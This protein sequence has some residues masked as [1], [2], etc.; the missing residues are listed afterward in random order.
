MKSLAP[1]AAIIL[2]SFVIVGCTQTRPAIPANPPATSYQVDSFEL[3]ESGR[4]QKVRGA[5]VTPDFFQSVKE[6]PMLG[7]IFIPEDYSLGRR[8]VVV[9]NHRLWQQRFGADP[10]LIGTAMH[11]DGRTFTVVGVMPANFDIPPGTDMWIP[12]TN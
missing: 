12:R 11:L 1:T 6:P 9:L 3:Q 10:R 8:Q 4:T 5:S 2:C 7:R